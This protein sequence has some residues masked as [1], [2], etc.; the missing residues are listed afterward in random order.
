MDV[1]KRNMRLRCVP[2]IHL[3]TMRTPFSLSRFLSIAGIDLEEKA[4]SD[5][6]M[7]KYPVQDSYHLKNGSDMGGR[8]EHGFDFAPSSDALFDD[9]SRLNGIHHVN[10]NQSQV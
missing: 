10:G 1:M 8:S 4:P 2:T 7:Y 5:M 6:F 9:H 3:Q